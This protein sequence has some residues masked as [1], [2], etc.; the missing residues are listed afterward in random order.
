LGATIEVPTLSGPYSLEIPPGSAS[1]E[2]FRIRGRG[3]PDLRG[4]PHGDLHVQTFI[5]V[6]KR[7]SSEQERL[8]RELAEVEQAEVSP[9]RKS[10]LERIRDY[11]TP[12][13]SAESLEE[14]AP[15]KEQQVRSESRK[16]KK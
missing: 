11:F 7:L 5:E 6:P 10:F 13:E 1:G 2:V 4:G 15:A 14:A 3:M 16:G 12:S 9:H 8:L